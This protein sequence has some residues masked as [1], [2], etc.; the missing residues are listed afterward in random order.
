MWTRLRKSWTRWREHRLDRKLRSLKALRQST[1][2]K[3]LAEEV[4]FLRIEVLRQR[5][6]Y[7]TRLAEK[8][9]Q[10]DVAETQNRL[11]QSERAINEREINLLTMVIVRNQSRVVAESQN[12][13]VDDMMRV[14]RPPEDRADVASA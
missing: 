7:E 2:E 14:V 12:L 6:A 3:R 11:L 4:A 8:D 9:K 10:L 1:V 5:D 13:E